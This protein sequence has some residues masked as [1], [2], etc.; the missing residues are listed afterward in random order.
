MSKIGIGSSPFCGSFSLRCHS[1][2]S[3]MPWLCFARTIPKVASSSIDAS[4]LGAE[5]VADRTPAL[6]RNARLVLADRVVKGSL[7]IAN[8]VITGWAE[9][10]G[11][12]D[13]F[14]CGG[15][16]LAPGLVEL[17]TDHLEAHY[18]PRPHVRW[19]MPSA[20]LAYDAQIACAGVTT[21]FNSFRLGGDEVANISA[22][23]VALATAIADAKADD[24]LRA[25]HLTHLRCEIATSDV[26]ELVDRF[27][28]TLPV[29][30]LSLMD[31]TPGQRQFRDLDKARHYFARLGIVTEAAWTGL[32]E[33]R[34]AMHAQ[35]AAANRR[36][37]VAMAQ[38]RRIAIASH[39]DATADEVAEASADGVSIAEF[40]TTA[41]AAA[42]SHAAGIAVLMGAPNVV[43]GGSH[44][45][46]VAA[47]TLARAGTLDIL[48]S[49]YV[50]S[51]LLL[52]AFEL[53]LKVPGFD[54]ADAMRLV[55]V[56]PAKAAGL[57]DRGELAEGKRADL[58]LVRHGRAAPSLRG[59]WR[60][61]R[62]VA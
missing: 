41:E 60:E 10:D 6:F 61:G 47:E 27:T 38:T 1:H 28:A 56:N 30:L 25:D 51:S 40:P 49:D 23:A 24:T 11:P 58:I 29:E 18:M 39:D 21:V 2:S 8:G 12:E 37:L 9:G 15:D 26:V 45:G 35:H 48:S 19:H 13:G 43:R 32:L 3:L 20:V 59:V 17:H 50:P 52:A 4:R 14:D 34:Q 62:R 54:L 5:P 42:L 7:S 55:T 33:H 31:H 53:P 22:D 57:T 36:A 46:N 44:A 16:Y